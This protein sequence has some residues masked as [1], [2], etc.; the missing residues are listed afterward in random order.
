ML[1]QEESLRA[2]SAVISADILSPP[3]L[4]GEWSLSAFVLS[5][6]KLVWRKSLLHS[7]SIVAVPILEELGIHFLI[8]EHSLLS[9]FTVFTIAHSEELVNNLTIGQLVAS[10][11]F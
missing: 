6:V 11:D 5:D 9:V 8:L 10:A 4:P 3:V 1:I 7:L 2:H